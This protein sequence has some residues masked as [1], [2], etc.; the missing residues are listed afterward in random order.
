MT[1]SNL[2]FTSH[3][4]KCEVFYLLVF[5]VHGVWSLEL[6]K[7][8]KLNKSRYVCV[9]HFIKKCFAK[10]VNHFA[11]LKSKKCYFTLDNLNDV[12]IPNEH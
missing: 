3:F 11:L 6:A 7:G 2:E 12:T 10:Y 9:L 4:A 5:R 1:K 8:N